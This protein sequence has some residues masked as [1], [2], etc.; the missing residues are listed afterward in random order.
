M[1]S[2]YGTYI[3]LAVHKNKQTIN[4]RLLIGHIVKV[5][6][7][8]QFNLVVKTMQHIIGR[9]H[10]DLILCYHFMLPVKM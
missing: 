1:A 9:R 2:D 8:P 3:V 7:V 5:H 4:L 6:I 10:L